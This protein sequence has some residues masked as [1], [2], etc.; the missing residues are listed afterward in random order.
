[1]NNTF[2]RIALFSSIY[3]IVLIVVSPSIDHLF[4]SLEEDKIK[5]ENNFQILGEI[6]LHI[7]VLSVSWFYLNKYLKDFLE[8]IFSLKI[9]EH[10]STAIDF[11][12]ALSLV[13]L[14]KN[15]IDK[16]NYVTVEHPFRISEI[17][18]FK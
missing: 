17:Q 11:I 1:M 7:I 15:L 14:Q 13:G 2:F 16:I 3:V 12:A 4:S 18:L 5:K 9:K 10:T 8:K 6:I